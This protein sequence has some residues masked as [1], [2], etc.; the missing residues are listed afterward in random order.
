MQSSHFAKDLKLNKS[1]RSPAHQASVGLARTASS[2]KYKIEQITKRDGISLSQFN[3]LRILRG[4]G[5]PLPTM[6]VSQRMVEMEPGI[7]RLL[8]RLEKRGLVSRQRSESDARTVEC[9]ITELGLLIL[10]R[11]DGPI[12]QLE[13]RI[14]SHLT[15]SEVASL[16]SILSRLHKRS[17]ED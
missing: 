16:N 1:F 6:E 12:A 8:V 3:I 15:V 14:M 9:S 5:R 13:E 17:L 2:L 7:T 4:A 11:V 10:D